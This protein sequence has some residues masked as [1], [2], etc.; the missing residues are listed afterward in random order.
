MSKPTGCHL[1]GSVALKD[2]ATVFK[3]CGTLLNDRLKRFP[4]GETA[5]RSRFIE[6]LVSVFA[7][8]NI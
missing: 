8:F 2:E 7:S 5:E 1:V 3:A 6:L 4:D